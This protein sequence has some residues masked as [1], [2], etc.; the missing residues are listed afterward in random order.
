MPRR[1]FWES[2][3]LNRPIAVSYGHRWDVF[4]GPIPGPNRGHRPAVILGTLIVTMSRI[5][6][7]EW[8]VSGKEIV[9]MTVDC[10]GRI[11]GTVP[12]V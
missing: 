9:G 7:V 5:A 2:G 10:G 6:V 12:S 8:L 1:I 4:F 11:R 3:E